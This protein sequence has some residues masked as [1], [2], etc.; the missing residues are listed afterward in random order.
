M[1][2]EIET[3][4]DLSRV[5]AFITG[6]NEIPPLGFTVKPQI[7]FEDDA[8]H[9][10]P[11]ASTCGPTLYLPLVLQDISMF[12]KRMDYAVY[13]GVDFSNA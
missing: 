5:L 8:T 9:T 13:C 2:D 12:E 6:S 7:K 3:V 4:I 11:H 1:I 10:L